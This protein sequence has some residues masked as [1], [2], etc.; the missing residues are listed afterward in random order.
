MKRADNK[1]DS[2][3]MFTKIIVNLRIKNHNIIWLT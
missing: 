1:V 3:R 2:F